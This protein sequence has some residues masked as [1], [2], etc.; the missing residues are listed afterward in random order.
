MSWQRFF[1]S[2]RARKGAGASD[3][4]V[5]LIL[6]ASGESNSSKLERLA[7]QLDWA[8]DN[9]RL[10]EALTALQSIPPE[11][12]NVGPFDGWDVDSY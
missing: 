4:P 9:G 3:P 6:A 5:P 12:W 7:A 10:D 2:L 8:F 1:D 11:Q